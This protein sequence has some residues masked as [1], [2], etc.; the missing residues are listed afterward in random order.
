MYF[1]KEFM[2]KNKI[3][4]T[5]KFLVLFSAI[6][7]IF[8]WGVYTYEIEGD[9]V[10]EKYNLQFRYIIFVLI[11]FISIRILNDFK[12]KEFKIFFI[13]LSIILFLIIHFLLVTDFHTFQSFGNFKKIKLLFSYIFLIYLVL[14]SYYYYE[15]ILNNKL[16]MIK[17]FVAIF[18]LSS[19]VSLFYLEIPDAPYLC[20][21]IKKNYLNQSIGYVYSFREFIFAENSHLALASAP[22]ICFSIY[23]FLQIKKDKVLFLLVILFLLIILVKSSLTFYLSLILINILFLIFEYSR[24]NKITKLFYILTI[25]LSVL[26]IRSDTNCYSKLSYK[27]DKSLLKE[28]KNYNKKNKIKEIDSYSTNIDDIKFYI[29][30]DKEIEF[31]KQLTNPFISL[32]ARVIYRGIHQSFYTLMEKPFGWGF[33]NFDLSLNHYQNKFKR[34]NPKLTKFNINKHDG[35]SQL[36]KIICEFGIIGIFLYILFLY[37]LFTKKLSVENKILLLSFIIS[38]SLRGVGYFNGGFTLIMFI[39]MFELFLKK[40]KTFS[41]DLTTYNEKNYNNNTLPQ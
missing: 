28:Q 36:F 30:R 22:I 26:L 24:L 32:S 29:H 3:Q 8:F 13:F 10:L 17:Y 12:K 33:Q 18:L 14:F 5:E 19:I 27:V 37:S 6:S 41:T 21:G 23:Y 1:S 20:G 2:I 39:L 9:K 11:P 38:Q 15:L 25:I 31:I 16:L 7:F 34:I 4:F 35:G 40:D